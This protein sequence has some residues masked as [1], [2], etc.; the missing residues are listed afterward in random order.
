[1]GKNL[2]FKTVAKWRFSLKRKKLFEN[3]TK[4]KTHLNNDSKTQIDPIP[5]K[6]NAGTINIGARAEKS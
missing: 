4:P 6:K 5:Q 2:Y 1:V 3:I